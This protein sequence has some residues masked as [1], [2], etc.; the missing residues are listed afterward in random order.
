MAKAK[1]RSR[2]NASSRASK[3]P[4]KSLLSAATTGI[5]RRGKSGSRALRKAARSVSG[6]STQRYVAIGG[7]VLAMAGL[8]AAAYTMLKENP[9]TR[10]KLLGGIRDLRTKALSFVSAQPPS[11]EHADQAVPLH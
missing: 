5:R 10:E 1:S 11:D 9:E 7:G 4:V 8:A 2:S 6:Y 3:S